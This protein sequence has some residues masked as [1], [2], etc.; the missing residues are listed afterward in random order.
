MTI[1]ICMREEDHYY[2]EKCPIELGVRGFG[3][4]TVDIKEYSGIDKK[5]HSHIPNPRLN[6]ELLL[7]MRKEVKEGLERLEE[8][9]FEGTIYSK[10]NFVGYSQKIFPIISIVDGIESIIKIARQQGIKWNIPKKIEGRYW[11]TDVVLSEDWD[12]TKII[13][14]SGLN[15]WYSHLCYAYQKPWFALH[16]LEFYCHLEGGSGGP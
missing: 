2:N 14:G 11:E 1:K 13:Y 7:R 12:K 3:G 10:I 15:Q 5:G 4:L 9:G 6:I 8:I 16:G